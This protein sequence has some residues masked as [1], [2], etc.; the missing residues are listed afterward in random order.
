ML[1]STAAF[2]QPG[3]AKFDKIQRVEIK[4]RIDLLVLISSLATKTN[5]NYLFP[6]QIK[7]FIR[8]IKGEVICLPA[9]AQRT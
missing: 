7:T 2:D 4:I 5:R 1:L 8:K 9:M 3:G 6:K